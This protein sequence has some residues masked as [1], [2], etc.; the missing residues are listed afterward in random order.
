M[1]YSSEHEWEVSG[2]MI[3]LRTI[4]HGFMVQMYGIMY[5]TNVPVLQVVCIKHASKYFRVKS[6][7]HPSIKRNKESTMFD[8]R[9]LVYF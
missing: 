9:F 4:M 1:V 6:A 5:G 2:N 8:E 3:D 7:L